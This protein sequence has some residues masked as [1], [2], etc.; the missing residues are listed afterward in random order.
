[1]DI[2]GA[3][4]GLGTFGQLRGSRKAMIRY[5]KIMHPFHFYKMVLVYMFWIVL[6]T[7]KGNLGDLGECSGLAYHG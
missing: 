1:M 5:D 3:W 4:M 2:N 7:H 6:G